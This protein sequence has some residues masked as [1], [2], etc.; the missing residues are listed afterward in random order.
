MRIH[1][2]QYRILDLSNFSRFFFNFH[3]RQA[4]KQA[5]KQEACRQASEP[6]SKQ[7]SKATSL[8]NPK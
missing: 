8:A 2:Q 7:A 4:S 1:F 6:A 3:P 5:S